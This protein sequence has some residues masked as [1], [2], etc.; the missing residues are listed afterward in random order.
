MVSLQ[1][2][3]TNPTSDNKIEEGMAQNRRTDVYFKIIEK[4]L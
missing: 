1:G 3:I 2:C 4:F